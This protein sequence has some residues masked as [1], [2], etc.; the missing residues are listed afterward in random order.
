[1]QRRVGKVLTCILEWGQ[2]TCKNSR[3]YP[4]QA[5]TTIVVLVFFIQL[6]WKLAIENKKKINSNELATGRS[7]LEQKKS[8]VQH[9]LG[10][11]SP[12]QLSL[13]QP[14]PWSNVSI[15]PLLLIRISIHSH[16]EC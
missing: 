5:Y 1:M 12:G 11:L 3:P 15:F 10:Q 2:R 8:S 4:A 14:F 6:I 7:F 16:N 13:G 9:L